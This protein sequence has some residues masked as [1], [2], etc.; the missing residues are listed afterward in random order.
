MH[1]RNLF[2]TVAS[3][4]VMGASFTLMSQ[5]LTDGVRVTLPYPVTIDDVVL[6]PGEYEIRRPSTT[7][8]Q[9]LSFYNKDKLRYQTVALSV[10]AAE[11]RPPE[12]TK[13]ILHHIGD[14]YYI[15]KIWIEG[16]TYGSEFPLPERARALQKELAA[17][18]AESS[19]SAA[20]QQPQTSSTS[21]RERVDALAP[22]EPDPVRQDS[23]NRQIPSPPVSSVESSSNVDRQED[24]AAVQRDQRDTQA[25]PAVD[26]RQDSGQSNAQGNQNRVGAA[27]SQ[28]ANELPETASGWL[29]YLLSGGLLLILAAYCRPVRVRG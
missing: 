13:V 23:Q 4:I 3:V 17:A 1:P 11:E 6:E 21:S 24:I 12:E 18:P 19:G 14:S 29:V 25:P 8:D 10:P 28:P 7:S 16:R 26:A 20:P 27:P 9:V 22:P 5:G 15:D 2:L